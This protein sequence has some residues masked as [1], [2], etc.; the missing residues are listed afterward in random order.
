MPSV[1][2]AARNADLEAFRARCRDAAAYS[3]EHDGDLVLVYRD[4]EMVFEDAS[5]TY[6]A[7]TPH[8]LAS[9][10]KSFVGVAA[11]C[12]VADGLLTLDEPVS[13]T[14]HE[15]K[16]DPRKSSVTI[17]QLLSLASGLEGLSATIDSA[18]NARAAGITDRAT[19]SIAGRSLAAPGER[20]IYGPSSFYVFG[21]LLKRKL[22]AAKTGDADIAAYLDRRIFTPLGIKPSFMRDEAGNP[23]MA[24]GCRISAADWVRFGEFMRHGGTHDGQSLLAPELVAQLTTATGPNP[25]YGL[26]WWLLDSSGEDAEDLVA[27]DMAADRLESADG[28]IRRRLAQRMRERARIQEAAARDAA[29]A[30]A[31]SESPLGYMAAGKGKQRLYVLP[32]HGLT[33]VRFGALTGSRDFHDAEFLGKLLGPLKDASAEES[34]GESAGESKDEPG[35]PR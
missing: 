5:A 6:S 35:A 10:T 26:T 18:A 9:G 16:S 30:R 13:A 23:N 11:M 8:V 4:G 28:P 17:R 12:A 31:P 27:A 2:P 14:I 22:V 3:R 20:F 1:E 34:A 32:E 21:E 19:A 15:W 7:R 25:R 33:I 24:G 29:A